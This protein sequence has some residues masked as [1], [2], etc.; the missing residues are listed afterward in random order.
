RAAN[1]GQ[2]LGLLPPSNTAVISNVTLSPDSP[3][4]GSNLEIKGSATTETNIDEDDLFIFA[5]LDVT[6]SPPQPVFFPE[7][8]YI[9]AKTECNNTKTFNFDE[10]YVLSLPSL[11]VKFVVGVAIGPNSSKVK[12]C[13][14][15]FF[16]EQ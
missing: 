7:P 11:P 6:V 3:K 14:V 4:A 15:A 16:P 13:G 8:F 9:C 2:C 12:A 10:N 1:F 5:I